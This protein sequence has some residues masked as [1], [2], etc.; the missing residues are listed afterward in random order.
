M[1][2][3][4]K[5]LGKYNQIIFQSPK[6]PLNLPPLHPLLLKWIYS[7]E[8]SERQSGRSPG[9]E[10]PG[11]GGAHTGRGHSGRGQLTLAPEGQRARKH[12]KEMANALGQ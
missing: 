11:V 5:K 12:E 8:A 10:E 1:G 7:R 9:W 3:K 2:I 4:Q 6:T